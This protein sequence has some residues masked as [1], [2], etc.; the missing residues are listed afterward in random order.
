MGALTLLTVVEYAAGCVIEYAAASAGTALVGT[1]SPYLSVAYGP[2]FATSPCGG[3][4][5][6]AGPTV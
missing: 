4:A 6:P 5:A 2:T 3:T 1:E